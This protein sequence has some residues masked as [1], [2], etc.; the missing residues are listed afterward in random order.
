MQRHTHRWEEGLFAHE[1]GYTPPPTTNVISTVIVDGDAKLDAVDVQM[2]WRRIRLRRERGTNTKDGSTSRPTAG[3][4]DGDDAD[5]R[6]RDD[7]S[8][9]MRCAVMFVAISTC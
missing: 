2:G 9:A 7:G 5:E 8:D 3:D 6:R 4:T 1:V